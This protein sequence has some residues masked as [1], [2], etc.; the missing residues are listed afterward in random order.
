[1]PSMSLPTY[2]RDSTEIRTAVGK[3]FAVEL[4]ASASSGYDWAAD[5]DA[6]VVAL[7]SEEYAVPSTLAFGAT[8]MKSFVFEAKKAGVTQLRFRHWRSFSGEV[9]EVLTIAAEVTS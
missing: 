2:G 9:A 3:Q 5:F 6:G 8:T 1:M 7:M 4:P